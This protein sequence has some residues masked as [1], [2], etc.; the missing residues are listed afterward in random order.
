VPATRRGDVEMFAHARRIRTQQRDA[1]YPGRVRMRVSAG[2]GAS[3]VA[4]FDAHGTICKRGAAW[5]YQSPP[6]GV[7]GPCATEIKEEN[8]D[9]REELL[10]HSVF[11]RSF[12]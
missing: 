2:D 7:R 8:T 9:D 6:G 11:F 1:E 12:V 5:T 4:P 3:A 10:F